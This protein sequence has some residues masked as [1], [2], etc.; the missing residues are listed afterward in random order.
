M[1]TIFGKLESTSM[2]NTTGIGIGLHI[3]KNIVEAFDGRIYLEKAKARGTKITFEIKCGRMN[4]VETNSEEKNESMF[5][6][7]NS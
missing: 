5:E 3:C 4:E 7:M 1:F 6:H 2:L